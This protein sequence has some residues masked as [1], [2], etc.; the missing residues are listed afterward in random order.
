[1][2]RAARH[3]DMPRLVEMGR[4]FLA[5]T[6]LADFTE[7]DDDSFS[8]TLTGMIDGDRAVLIVAEESQIIGLIGGLVYPF[9]FN[10]NHLTGQEMFWWVEPAYRKGAGRQLF[11]ALE[12]W[13]RE[14]GA[15]TLT[16][17]ALDSNRPEAVTA[18][19]KRAGYTPTERNF[20][21]AL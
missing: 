14:M 5:E 6:A 9:Y 15:K 21:R 11:K 19:Y 17:M 4:A 12:T 2:I 1:M 16:V 18:A 10:T 8:R 3:E 20:M 13:A 7:I